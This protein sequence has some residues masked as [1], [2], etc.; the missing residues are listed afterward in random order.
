MIIN[1][2]LLFSSLNSE[3]SFL[4]DLKNLVIDEAHNIEDSI[5][6]SLKESYSLKNLKEFFDRCE[7]VF[8][9]KNIK[10]IDF[11]NDKN[12]IITNLEILDEYAFSYINETVDTDNP[13]K[14]ILAK[15]DYFKELEYEDILKKVNLLIIDII[16]RL[17]VIPEYDFSKEVSFFEKIA[18]NIFTFFDKN[19]SKEYI[20]ILS[21]N[22]RA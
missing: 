3:N 9:L 16:D 19:N 6:E 20:K 18:K 7:K 21:Y 5:T 17:R 8:R 13:Y 22:D 12:A 10:Q 2:S 1:H 4:P 15:D 11:I 14:T